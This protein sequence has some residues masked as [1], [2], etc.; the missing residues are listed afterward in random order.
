M[1]I[2]VNDIAL[3]LFPNTENQFFI[4]KQIYDIRSLQTRKSDFTRTLELP[5]SANNLDAL[6]LNT[7]RNL[8]GSKFDC[9]LDIDGIIISKGFLFVFESTNFTISINIYSGNFDLFN[10]IP[11]ESIKELNLSSYNF[12]F[13]V[14]GFVAL[15]TATDGPVL[16]R[17]YWVDEETI[18]YDGANADYNGVLDI[19]QAGFDIFQK[20]L[21]ELII[22]NA[23]YTLD[24]SNLSSNDYYNNLVLACPLPAFLLEDIAG[25][26][27]SDVTL[28]GNF[29]YNPTS[30]TGK[31]VVPWDSVTADP[32]SVFDAINYTF[33]IATAGT[34][35]VECNYNID[36]TQNIPAS[37]TI[38]L[39]LNGS[40]IDSDTYFIGASG[41]V[42]TL[43]AF[44]TFAVNDVLRVCVR[45]GYID[46]S[47][48]DQIVVNTASN[49]TIE[50]TSSPVSGD[51]I[52]S[53]WL[54]DINQKQF[55]RDFCKFFNLI[56]EVDPYTKTITPKFFKDYISETPQEIGTLDASK[57]VKQIL[58]LPYYRQSKFEFAND[59]LLREDSD[60]IITIDRDQNINVAGTILNIDYS[61][62]DLSEFQGTGTNSLYTP[63][64][65][66]S[67]ERFKNFSISSGA[68]NFTLSTTD[69]TVSFIPGQYICYGASGLRN[70]IH[71]IS[72][73]TGLGTG[74]F[75]N[76]SN[77]TVSNIDA[78]LIT[79]ERN[80]I[81]PRHGLLVDESGSLN[82]N[83]DRFTPV[84]GTN[85]ACKTFT[86][87][88]METIYNEF[89]TE[90]I[91]II[92]EPNFISCYMVFSTVEV[93]Q[94]AMDKP[95]IVR[96]FTG[97]YHI[98]K[99][100]QWKVNQPCL[101]ELI[102]LNVI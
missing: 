67:W 42:G 56:F 45:C 94:L 13:S 65:R 23:G 38:Q 80:D 17:H 16:S 97:K 2:L 5:A 36:Y 99:I 75:Y 79:V 41:I 31:G 43:T 35:I 95:I 89:Y 1:K 72:T 44:Q 47:N 85:A 14:A 22:E 30:S 81:S 39:E 66:W 92:S 88:T 78:F 51:V 28:S 64:Y 40:V 46:A 27:E 12:P 8:T 54:P 71:R 73:R 52:V 87:L 86:A 3:D 15:A 74:T 61:N 6:G 60:F 48:R 62:S 24:D 84:T 70:H 11:N 19:K 76:N 25:T 26:S 55:I 49:F 82:V 29:T 57:P 21:F 68:S 63:H 10:N 9:L 91:N 69:Q 37:G 32:L 59:D 101:V 20:T 53:D 4:N 100:E 34:Y 102:R 93:Y 90:F 18:Y 58:E 83:S 77:I 98:N 96:P 50:Q 7:N 33:V